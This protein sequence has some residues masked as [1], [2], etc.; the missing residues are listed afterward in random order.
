LP[1]P[2]LSLTATEALAMEG[3]PFFKITAETEAI[4]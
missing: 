3:E 2:I 1:Q 4:T